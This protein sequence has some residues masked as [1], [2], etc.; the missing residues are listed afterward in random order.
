MIR[1]IIV[2]DE[3]LARRKVRTFLAPEQDFEILTECKSG[4]EAIEAIESLEPDLV[5]LDIQMPGINGFD[6]LRNTPEDKLPLVVFITAYDRYAVR[7]FDVHALDYLLKPFDENRFSETLDRVRSRI[8]PERTNGTRGK[9]LELLEEMKSKDKGADRILVK[10]AG[11][12]Y[13]MPT[14]TIDW[15]EAAGNYVT[16]HA[17]SETHIMRETMAKLEKQLPFE[18][19]VRVHRSAI[20]NLK[21]V[22]ELLPSIK[23]EFEI[24]LQNGD[25]ITLSRKYRPALEER[26][27][28]PL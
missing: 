9:I 7:A 27:G 23:G 13:F 15:I 22:K 6:V 3:P 24:L 11:R 1:T 25:R 16:F 10:S 12:I 19:F 8:A 2:D 14:N 26:L 4:A 20:I 17:K 18:Q 28:K 5:F 21:K